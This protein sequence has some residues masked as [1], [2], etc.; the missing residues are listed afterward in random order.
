MA[1]LLEGKRL[2]GQINEDTAAYASQHDL[3]LAVIQVGDD[4]A[5]KAYREAKK[6]QAHRLGIIFEEYLFDTFVPVHEIEA[7]IR[8]LNS[9]EEITGIFIEQPLPRGYDPVSLLELV[10]PAKDIDGVTA[11][12]A[13]NLY[14]NR[15]GLFPAT[16]QA[17]VRIL[18]FYHIEPRGREAV[19]VGRSNI[20][21]KP[22]ALLLLHRHATVTLCHSRTQALKDVVRRGDIVI[23][24]VGKSE[25]LKGDY[26]KE[27]AV[28]LDAG[29]NVDEDRITGDVDFEGALPRVSA[30]TPVPGG[31]GS[32][33]TASLFHNLV[34]A[35]QLQYGT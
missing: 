13:A 18:D 27:G 9:R 12:N 17:L 26:F 4:P 7:L 29:Y 14:F 8:Q 11:A 2:A 5:S 32:V 10:D 35:R 28:V 31:V 21:G 34:K 6:R 24:A 25:L 22:A 19:V 15:P 1:T 3:T 16:A 30:I 20:V 33:T 23:A